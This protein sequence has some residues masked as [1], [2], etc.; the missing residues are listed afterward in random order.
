MEYD[1]LEMFAHDMAHMQYT[2][3]EMLLNEVQDTVANAKTNADLVNLSNTELK[4]VT[5][6]PSWIDGNHV[7]MM[8]AVKEQFKNF[9]FKDV[10][11]NEDGVFKDDGTEVP[12][13]DVKKAL[14]KG[15]DN[16]RIVV[17]NVQD[18]TELDYHRREANQFRKSAV[19][20]IVNEA[21]SNKDLIDLANGPLRDVKNVMQ[22]GSHQN[23]LTMYPETAELG[24]T[25]IT[26]TDSRIF[27]TDSDID[28]DFDE[29]KEQLLDSLDYG[30]VVVEPVNNKYDE[31]YIT[32]DR[33]SM[34]AEEFEHV[35]DT[36]TE[37][38]GSGAKQAAVEALNSAHT[39]EDLIKIVK[40]P[41]ADFRVTD[42]QAGVDGD[43]LS[44]FKV[45]GYYGDVN[46]QVTDSRIYYGDIDKDMM[47]TDAKDCLVDSV[48]KGLALYEPGF[49]KEHYE[50]I[51]LN[52]DG[53]EDDK[54]LQQ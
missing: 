8:D 25:N 40:G 38:I 34:T 28:L 6:V 4:G 15:L 13:D 32:I 30:T 29:A 42:D 48:E 5:F 47:F 52:L 46:I 23:L 1:D 26:V 37:N 45:N 9:E 54:G 44:Q 11:I 24:G 3:N 39:N 16:G 50:Q 22:D 21:E 17:S 7:N 43:L 12:V 33:P 19:K 51:E 35:V 36:Y 10:T 14:Y 2:A 41:L 20:D 18:G 53:L 31:D 27:F 49:G